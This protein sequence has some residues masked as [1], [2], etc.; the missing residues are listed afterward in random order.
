VARRSVLQRDW[1]TRD[2]EVMGGWRVLPGVLAV[3]DVVVAG[4]ED[5]G[6]ADGAAH[7]GVVLVDS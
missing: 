6:L 4:G 3:S 1:E 7:G 5:G 2:L